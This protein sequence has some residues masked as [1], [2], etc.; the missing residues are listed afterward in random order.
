[1][2]PA[3]HDFTLT[4]AAGG[5]AVRSVL[6]NVPAL[7]KVLTKAAG[8]LDDAV[9]PIKNT[10]DN[11]T[12]KTK[13]TAA[14][15]IQNAKHLGSQHANQL[16]Y[17]LKHPI[18]A[19]VTSNSG[20]ASIRKSAKFID[21]ALRPVHVRTVQTSTGQN[22]VTGLE[23][24]PSEE[25]YTKKADD[26]IAKM[27]A[28]KEIILKNNEPTQLDSFVNLMNEED[29]KR[30]NQ[31]WDKTE[32]GMNTNDRVATNLQSPNS[33]VNSI[34]PMKLMEHNLSYDDFTALRLKPDYQLNEIEQ[35]IMQDIRDSVVR[36]DGN[37]TLIK[38]IHAND[39]QKYLDGSYKSIRG[40]VAKADDSIHIHE[41]RHVRESMRLD[42]SYFD[43]FRE[44][45]IRPYLE[46]GN[47]Y[48]YIEFYAKDSQAL[49][50][51]NLEIPY[52]N[53][54]NQPYSG[55]KKN[56]WPWTGNG[57]TSSRNGEV[58]PEWTTIDPID[59]KEGAILH[60]VINGQDEIIAIFDGKSFK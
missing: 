34:L 21:E 5:L 43:D 26:F 25:V 30:Y 16:Q 9:K 14:S 59:I 38:N 32:I 47:S 2:L 54:F 33:F 29:A 40:F 27:Q 7:A 19:A 37:T 52:G 12:S 13:Q 44:Q 46:D 6:K 18:V 41:Y 35:K 50:V 57:F 39:I 58:I 10:V 8:T 20:E 17:M 1:M 24:G 4:P 56:E 45:V 31:F 55:W 3:S 23:R 48:G 60:R 11:I 22:I 51:K 49:S 28:E 15:A 36:P 53:N 42:Y